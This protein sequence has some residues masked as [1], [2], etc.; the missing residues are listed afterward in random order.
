MKPVVATNT[1]TFPKLGDTLL[2]ELKPKKLPEPKTG[3]FRPYYP[4]P[5]KNPSKHYKRRLREMKKGVYT[6]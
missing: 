2:G 6:R 5:K 4:K 1:G 3:A